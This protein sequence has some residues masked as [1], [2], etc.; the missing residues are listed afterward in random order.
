MDAVGT[1]VVTGCRSIYLI[2]KF[3]FRDLSVN[4]LKCAPVRSA[5]TRENTQDHRGYARLVLY[6]KKTKAVLQ[7]LRIDLESIG[8]PAMS[9]WVT[10]LPRPVMERQNRSNMDFLLTGVSL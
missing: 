10:P 9:W 8:V 2:N 7:R 4:F 3:I 1:V 5:R 6:C